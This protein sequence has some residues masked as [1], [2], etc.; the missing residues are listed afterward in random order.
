MDVETVSRAFAA[1][2]P[3]P[4]LGL[5]LA[6]G[7]SLLVGCDY[8][9]HVLNRIG[10]GGDAWTRARYA[11][12]GFREYVEE[13]LHPERLNVS[14]I[15]TEIA[16]RY[17]ATTM[18]LPQVRSTYHE[19][20]TDPT[21]LPGAVR[22]Q[23]AAARTLRNVHSRRQLEQVLVDFWFNHFNVDARADLARWG[24]VTFE[25]QA[26]RPFVFGRFRDMLGA[27]AAH[28]A[29]LDYLDNMDN[30]IPGFKQGTKLFGPNE[31]WGRELLELHTVG[32]DAGYTLQDVQEV[33]R[34]FT[35]WTIN[36]YRAN[37]S[38]NYFADSFVYKDEGHDKGSKSIMG[39]LFIPAGGGMDDGLDVLDYLARRPETARHIAFKLCQRF[40]ADEPPPALVEQIAAVFLNT[41]GD[42]R[43]VTRAILLSPDFLAPKN[44]RSKVKRP[45]H[46]IASLARSVGVVDNAAFAERAAGEATRLGEELFGAGP[47]TGY[48]ETSPYWRGAGPL[49]FR[50]NVALWATEGLYG[51]GPPVMSTAWSTDPEL[52]VPQLTNRF[53][54]GGVSTVTRNGLVDLALLIPVQSRGGRTAATL[55]MSPEFLVH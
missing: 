21:L 42:L 39:G 30:F 40:V 52:L 10:Y 24:V 28:P 34:A 37:G 35:G 9:E 8:R 29:M 26:I 4:L 31:N 1:Q 55:L 12:L 16:N 44:R 5:V 20:N 33:A 53:V 2:R 54:P 49:V 23:M 43:E 51:F 36:Q 18:T 46:F 41:D 14:A 11:E 50:M 27:V 47:P 15:E 25:R 22:Q 7:L 17:P 38:F 48:P 6:F 32:V 13:Q 19:Y 3:R 45:Q